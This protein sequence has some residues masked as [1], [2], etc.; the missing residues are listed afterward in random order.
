MVIKLK[1]IVEDEQL[2]S[3]SQNHTSSP[4]I[5][6]VSKPWLPDYEGESIDLLS[7]ESNVKSVVSSWMI[8]FIKLTKVITILLFISTITL[9]LLGYEYITF[10]F[11]SYNIY[12][13]FM[14]IGFVNILNTRFFYFKNKKLSNHL[15]FYNIII[16]IMIW[17]Q[18]I[19]EYEK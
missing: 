19:T 7:L 16:L 14:T 5:F 8:F 1:K 18:A 10:T 6:N 17:G 15:L 12:G 11:N 3:S 4:D 9:A 13:I 2:E